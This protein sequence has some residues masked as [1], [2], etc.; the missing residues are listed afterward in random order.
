MRAEGLVQRAPLQPLDGTDLRAVD[1]HREHQARADGDA[2][3]VYRAGAAHAVLAAD[4]RTR[5][6]ERVPQEVG[7]EQARLHLFLVPPAV[8][9][10]LDHATR[11]TT[12]STRTRTRLRR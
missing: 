10:D 7:E 1:L 6:P 9:C 4:V 12:L 2:V 8:D 5:Q 11:S 3:E